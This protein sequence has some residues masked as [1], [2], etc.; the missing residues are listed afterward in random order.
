MPSLER[1]FRSHPGCASR[2]MASPAPAAPTAPR[3]LGAPTSV[4]DAQVGAV[5]FLHRLGYSLN[6]HV[7][8]Y[9]LA[10]DGVCSD[11]GDRGLRFH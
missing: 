4:L 1:D 2:P 10:V 11:G 3:S 6:A 5:S 7:H 9:V 8:D